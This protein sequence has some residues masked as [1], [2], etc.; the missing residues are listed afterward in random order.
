MRQI[1]YHWVGGNV[2]GGNLTPLLAFQIEKQRVLTREYLFHF[3]AFL[4]V[5]AALHN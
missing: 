5:H 2:E 3:F 4:H 1:D